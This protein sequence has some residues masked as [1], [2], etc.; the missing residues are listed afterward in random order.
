MELCDYFIGWNNY[1]SYFTIKN[2]PYT[3]K[4]ITVDYLP[5]FLLSLVMCGFV[6]FFGKLPLIT[7]VLL[8][9]QILVGVIVYVVG[10]KI[11]NMQ[12]LTYVINYIKE[13]IHR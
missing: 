10:A 11:F 4:E 13:K 6:Y 8:L 12:E 9:L 5:S 1:F 7:P 3:L 2:F